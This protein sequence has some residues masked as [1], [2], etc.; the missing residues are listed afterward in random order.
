MATTQQ[1]HRKREAILRYIADFAMRQGHSPS[2]REVAEGV[3]LTSTSTV[4]AHLRRLHE[5]NLID[6]YPF[7]PRSI[8]L[9]DAGWEAVGT[10]PCLCCG[11]T[12]RVSQ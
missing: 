3:S 4:A 6:Y 12:G 8:R 1:G 2:V 9:T 10:R 5:T 11:G 7:C